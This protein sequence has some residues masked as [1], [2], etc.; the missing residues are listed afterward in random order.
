MLSPVCPQYKLP[1]LRCCP[2]PPPQAFQGQVQ[3]LFGL[4]GELAA[5]FGVRTPV[6]HAMFGGYV[7]VLTGLTEFVLSIIAGKRARV[8]GVHALSCCLQI[9]RDLRTF[10]A[11]IG[12]VFCS[13][14]FVM[15]GVYIRLLCFRGLPRRSGRHRTHL[16]F[17][18]TGLLLQGH[19]TVGVHERTPRFDMSRSRSSY[20][21][22]YSKENLR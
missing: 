15:V 5:R 20:P 19:V 16:S 22:Q 18:R 11:Y 17:R 14:F 9:C 12:Y 1:A 3:L 13:S 21:Q 10:C 8:G 4:L 2:L 6:Q 7:S